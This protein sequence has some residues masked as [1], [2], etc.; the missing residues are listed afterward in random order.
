MVSLRSTRL[1]AGAAQTQV[2][3]QQATITQPAL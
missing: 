1:F 3:L 2:V